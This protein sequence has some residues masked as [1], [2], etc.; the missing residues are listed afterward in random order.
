[1]SGSAAQIADLA[2]LERGELTIEG[3]ITYDGLSPVRVR[4]GKRD[5]RYTVSDDG[6]AVS[7][8]GIDTRR[9]ALPEQIRLGEHSVNVSGRG[10]VWL[11]AVAPSEEWLTRL[12]GLVEQGS[13]A[14]YEQLLELDEL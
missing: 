14:L 13:V 7:A 11:P 5:R 8:A 3:S 12:C 1:V 9:L 2:A 4:V 10:V 6:A